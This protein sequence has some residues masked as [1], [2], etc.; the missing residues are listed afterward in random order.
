[1]HMCPTV[2]FKDFIV[3]LSAIVKLAFVGVLINMVLNLRIHV[4]E[5]D[6]LVVS[7]TYYLSN[8]FIILSKLKSFQN[9]NDV[10]ISVF[11]EQNRQ[12]GFYVYHFV[13]SKIKINRNPFSVS[14]SNIC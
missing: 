5:G 4:N 13:K 3:Q 8:D 12:N 9:A 2:T 1:M 10:D 14:Y 11:C 6:R 7:M